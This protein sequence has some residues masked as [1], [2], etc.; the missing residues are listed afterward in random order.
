MNIPFVD[1]LIVFLAIGALLRGY[2]IGFLRQFVSTVA[3]IVGLFPGSWLSAYAMEH[4][5]GPSK[6]LAGLAILLTVCFAL[7]TVGE[8]LAVRL[9]LA[10]Q[11][12]AVQRTD[13]A[14]GAAMSVVTLLLGLWLAS[15]LFALAPPSSVQT[16]LKSSHILGTLN[17]EL[18]PASRVLKS[19][20]T[21][22][23]PNQFPEVFAGREPS[24]DARQTLP[25]PDEFTAMLRSIEPSVLK[26]EGLGCGGIVDGSGFVFAH[27]LVATNAHVVAGVRSPK[28]RTGNEAFNTIVIAFDPANDI[29]I[30]R[31]PGLP[32]PPLSI[33]RMYPA[34]GSAAFA[35]G[36]PGGGEYQVSPAI[37]LD[38]FEALGQ[39]IYGKERVTREVYSL[40]T[41]IVRGN[42]GGPVVATDGTVV[43][44]VFATSTAYNNI[45]Y[46]LTMEQ[47]HEHL[48]Q[49]ES[50]STAVSTGQCSE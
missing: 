17:G 29:A 43:G 25:N 39:D 33:N 47:V 6:P 13:N 49:A 23:D 42:S 38:R 46:A 30:L 21:I 45:G 15:A 12:H 27:E 5:S 8:L 44:V 3:F 34:T 9:K 22:I 36:Y 7:M 18:P 40:Q 1:F 28:V 24:P 4:I 2:Q 35:L 48:K 20:N 10:V 41:T 37:V 26:V 31:V 11:S 16:Q 19:L 14:I 32:N 50:K